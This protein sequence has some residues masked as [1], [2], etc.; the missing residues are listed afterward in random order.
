MEFEESGEYKFDLR[1]WPKEIEKVTT[2]TSSEYGES[3]NID[4]AR[5]KIWN[6]DQVYVD[7]KKSA[8]GKKD[9]VVFKTKDLPKGPAFIQTWFYSEDGEIEG[10]VYYNYVNKS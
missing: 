10:A 1:R 5:I 9:G 2:L 3:L 4:S 6:G 8:K 7:M